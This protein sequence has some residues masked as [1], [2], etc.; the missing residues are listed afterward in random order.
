M[1]SESR[2]DVDSPKLKRHS[3]QFDI[4]CH[5]SP[6]ASVQQPKIPAGLPSNDE[7]TNTTFTTYTH[8]TILQNLSE[9]SPVQSLPS[10]QSSLALSFYEELPSMLP[11]KPSLPPI[12]SLYTLTHLLPPMEDSLDLNC[13]LI[14]VQAQ[15]EYNDL[16]QYRCVDQTENTLDVEQPA[17]KESSDNNVEILNLDTA[18]NF[19]DFTVEEEKEFDFYFGSMA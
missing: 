10:F 2:E 13:V 8:P 15:C 9:E 19:L 5:N 6:S 17:N 7:E 4:G 1:V 16:S 3:G 18:Q 14:P 12:P 11:S